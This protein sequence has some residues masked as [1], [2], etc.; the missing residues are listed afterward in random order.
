MAPTSGMRL[1]GVDRPGYGLSSPFPG[2][3]LADWPADIAFLADHLGFKRF[4][5]LGISGGAPYALACARY[6]ADRISSVGIVC[7]VGP[8]DSSGMD[9]GT[10]RMLL[11]FGRHR[12]SHIPLVELARLWLTQ[13]DAEK[14]F[15]EF[16]RRIIERLAADSPKEQAVASDEVLR[17]L[18]VSWAE[19]L[20]RSTSGMISDARIYATP[21][22][23]ALKDI[24]A[25]IHLWHGTEDRMVPVEVG[26]A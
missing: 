25:K 11:R 13:G 5:V 18:F 19:G 10:M 26:R 4:G 15:L 2:R 9:G 16:R 14:R 1:V 7:G 3:G 6:L 23:F 8:P 12:I 24:N 21:W 20:R 17:N 22:P